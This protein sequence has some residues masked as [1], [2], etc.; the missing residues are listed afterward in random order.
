MVNNEPCCV[1]RFARHFS[2]LDAD[3]DIIAAVLGSCA[4]CR[5][6]HRRDYI[7]VCIGDPFGKL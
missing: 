7:G 4:D 2:M 3:T 6:R 5:L 1:A